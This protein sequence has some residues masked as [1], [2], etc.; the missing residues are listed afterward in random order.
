MNILIT[1]SFFTFFRGVQ[2]KVIAT[3]PS[4]VPVA[5]VGPDTV[6]HFEGELFPCNF[7]LSVDVVFEGLHYFFNQFLSIPSVASTSSSVCQLLQN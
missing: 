1:V 4:T 5:R 2:F 7:F 3:E 6:V